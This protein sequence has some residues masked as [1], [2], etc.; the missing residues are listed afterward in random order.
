VDLPPFGHEEVSDSQDIEIFFERLNQ[1]LQEL[2]K[3]TPRLI[4][5]S[6]DALLEAFG[7]PQGEEG[8]DAFV[9]MARE[10]APK[11]THPQLLPLLLRASDGEDTRQTL[12]SVL[13]YVA[14]RPPRKWTDR[15]EEIYLINLETQSSL[16]R[17]EKALHFPDAGLSEKQ[18]IR[19]H[20][21]ARRLQQDIQAWGD[22]P[23]II[24]AALRMLLKE[25][26]TLSD[27]K[28]EGV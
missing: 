13:A 6:R 24:Q 10:L 12:E 7:F 20:E 11:V 15:D 23:E 9:R 3:V 17:M 2:M 19:S 1:A 26:E 16:F 8:W 28:G 14:N 22:D 27:T 21:L 5:R 25:M 4:N 18:R